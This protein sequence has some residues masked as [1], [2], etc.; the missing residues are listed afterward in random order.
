MKGIVIMNIYVLDALVFGYKF[1]R[2]QWTCL[3]TIWSERY[4]YSELGNNIYEFKDYVIV[5]HAVITNTDDS[6]SI[7]YDLQS[8]NEKLLAGKKEIDDTTGKILCFT[9]G[10]VNRP[11]PQIYY[12]HLATK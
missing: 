5:G 8:I 4:L 3:C 10:N 6:D 11:L 7:A 9:E 12:V 1:T 2:Q